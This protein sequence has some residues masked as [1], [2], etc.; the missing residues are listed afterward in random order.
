MG[1]RLVRVACSHTDTSTRVPRSAR[2]GLHP[3]G[4]PTCSAGHRGP[5]AT[6]GTQ[7]SRPSAIASSVSP[8]Q[9]AISSSPTRTP[10][11]RA[12]AR[13][14]A[15]EAHPP[16]TRSRASPRPHRSRGMHRP[17]FSA[18]RAGPHTL[19]AVTALTHAPPTT[20]HVDPCGA[21]GPVHDCSTIAAS[22]SMHARRPRPRN[23]TFRDVIARLAG[24]ALFVVP[25]RDFF[26]PR[27]M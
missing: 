4:T 18:R 5:S 14:A 19:S 16:P 17:S 20:G 3:G 15:E 1:Q 24:D 25:R 27:A 6:R 12:A 7:P 9:V 26:G 13:T 22:A 8:G 11:S 21:R 10:L 2:T 23:L